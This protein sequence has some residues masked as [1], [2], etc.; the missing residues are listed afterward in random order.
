MID[1]FQEQR[2]ELKYFITPSQAQRVREVVRCFLVPDEYARGHDEL[3]YPVH[4]IY[5]DSDALTTYWATVHC[6]K[7]RYKLRVRF[8]DDDPTSPVFLEIKRRQN[9]TIRKQRA[10]VRR[11]ALARVLGGVRPALEDVVGGASQLAAAE[12]FVMLARGLHARPKVRIAYLRD[13]WVDPVGNA[14]R[15]TFDRQ[16]RGERVRDMSLST[17][18]VDPVV[19]FGEQVVLEMKFTNRFPHWFGELVRHFDLAQCGVQKYCG[20]LALVGEERVSSRAQGDP[21]LMSYF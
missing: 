21:A 12:A 17:T 15:V 14:V 2:F 11:E 20:S 13:A 16:V 3:G 6:E 10:A 19:P 9:E 5:L 8:Y 1:R 4:S 7:Q 18:L